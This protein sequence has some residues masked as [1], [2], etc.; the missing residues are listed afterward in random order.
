LQ[1]AE[2][3]QLLR[4]FSA[5][6]GDAERIRSLGQEARKRGSFGKV[7]DWSRQ[8]LGL[9]SD[10]D[11]LMIWDAE[12][13]PGLVQTEDYA[14]AIVSTSVVVAPA[15]V[16]QTVKARIRRQSLV[17]RAA[18]PQL[19]IILG[20]AAL[21]REI[22][23]PKILRAQ[24]E[25]LRNLATL[26]HVTLQVLPFSSGEHAALGTSFTLLRLDLED[27]T[28]TYAYLEDLTRADCLDGHQHVQVY[29]MVIER[30]RI[31][32]MG[33]RETLEAL[34]R[35]IDDLASGDTE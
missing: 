16:D 2:L 35:A 4:L 6:P 11:A 10:A 8:Y 5:E 19:N 12:L 22:G 9:E 27:V 34:D 15:D 33:Q 25:H 17:T 18:P 7:P 14:R 21:R 24:L 28:F 29:E 20:E 30:L 3:D 1:T 26:P 31:A 32:A 23:G 13:V